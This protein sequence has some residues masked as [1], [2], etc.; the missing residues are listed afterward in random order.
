MCHI[1]YPRCET[2]NCWRWVDTHFHD[3]AGSMSLFVLPIKHANTSV[4]TI[5]NLWPL[6][7][8]KMQ[9]Q[10]SLTLR[11][12]S[13]PGSGRECLSPS[14][15]HQ[16]GHHIQK[17]TPRYNLNI[18]QLILGYFNTTMNWTV[19]NAEQE[20]GPD[21]SSQTRRNPGITRYVARSGPPRS[22]GCGFW[23][24]LQPNRTIF[25]VRIRT[26]GGFP[27]PIASTSHMVISACALDL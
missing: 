23:T 15:D 6:R 12:C 8:P 5:C 3:G 21:G 27:W 11:W 9:D 13:F 4:M 14:F 7:L 24:V 17:R 26:A 16:G 25:P 1:D 19:W 20:I 22:C 2:S 18:L 10:K